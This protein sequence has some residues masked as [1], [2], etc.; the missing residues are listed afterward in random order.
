[1]LVSIQFIIGSLLEPR[2]TGATLNLS[3]VVILLSLAIWGSI[4]GVIGMFLCVPL[5]TII[6]IILAQFDNTRPIAVLLTA[7]GKLP[8]K[9]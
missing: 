2:L 3:P 9:A 6:N 4:W 8:E 1:M 5:I 7:D